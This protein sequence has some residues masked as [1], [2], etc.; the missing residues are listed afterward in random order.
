MKQ[1]YNVGY[2]KTPSVQHLS[3]TK[4]ALVNNGIVSQITPNELLPKAIDE[5]LIDLKPENIRSN[6]KIGN[7][8]GNYV[9][10]IISKIPKLEDV[11]LN[12][13]IVTPYLGKG[14]TL[15]L[16]NG[17]EALYSDATGIYLVDLTTLEKNLIYSSTVAWNYFYEAQDGYVYASCSS[18]S[19]L[20]ILRIK[21]NEAIK[22]YGTGYYWRYFKEDSKGNIYV[23]SYNDSVN[24]VIHIKNGLAVLI[25]TSGYQFDAFVEDDKG[26]VY[27]GSTVSQNYRGAC[28]LHLNGSN[29]TLINKGF[30]GYYLYKTPN[31]D[32]F[33]S[34]DGMV[35][36]FLDDGVLTQTDILEYNYSN[37]INSYRVNFIDSKNNMYLGTNFSSNSTLVMLTG[38]TAKILLEGFNIRGSNTFE[39]KEGSIY[40]I[41][42]QY[43]S[44]QIIKIKDGTVSVLAEDLYSSN[45]N[46]YET[47]SG[48]VYCSGN[49]SSMGT[50]RIKNDVVE[51]IT[52]SSLN[53]SGSVYQY[54]WGN[55]FEVD[56]DKLYCSFI[57]QSSGS[58][59]FGVAYIEG[60]TGN[61]I[62]STPTIDFNKFAKIENGVLLSDSNYPNPNSTI[63]L[64]NGTNYATVKIKEE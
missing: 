10:D 35:F 48:I 50:I 61:K 60:L 44:K 42:Y 49:S 13:C 46:F 45:V 15:F 28:L 41:S 7:V 59:Y 24:G 29:V 55:F 58:S 34:A 52:F 20:G 51:N 32:I 12:H 3:D 23:S 53:N 36:G 14:T 30:K 6:V 33:T 21:G 26:N 31:G 37:G 27:L 56:N 47:P 57:N 5:S 8:T 11:D 43:G 1:T 62:L 63:Y 25:Y 18:S 9:A 4:K 19:G 22:I 17:I 2:I 54:Y 39:T 38:R 64:L 40:S 16:S